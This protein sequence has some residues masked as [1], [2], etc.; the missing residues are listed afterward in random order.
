MYGLRYNNNKS[1]YCGALISDNAQ[2]CRACG[3]STEET[4]P[5]VLKE[6]KKVFK[7]GLTGLLIST[8]GWLVAMFI[9]VP[10]AVIIET[11]FDIDFEST[12]LFLMFLSFFVPSCTSLTIG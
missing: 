10:I 3:A 7:L 2:F 6:Q 1:R 4:D 5:N 9:S 8:D 11:I 12:S